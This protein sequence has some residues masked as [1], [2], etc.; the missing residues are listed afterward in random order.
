[1]NA[2]K[3]IDRHIAYSGVVLLSLITWGCRCYD[4]FPTEDDAI[5]E[6]ETRVVLSELHSVAL[7]IYVPRAEPLPAKESQVWEA[8]RSEVG[9][10]LEA[11]QLSQAVE[12]RFEE[13]RALDGWGRQ[14]HMILTRTTL[15]LGSSGSDGKWEGG[16]GDDIMGTV[17]DLSDYGI[18]QAGGRPPDGSHD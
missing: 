17:I 3:R 18:E 1:M 5:D 11:G 10:R 9:Q 15:Q 12:F 6:A 16:K 7:D 8:I 14:M 2:R 13:G 4:P